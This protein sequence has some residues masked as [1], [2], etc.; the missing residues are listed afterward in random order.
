MDQEATAAS[1]ESDFHQAQLQAETNEGL[2]KEGLVAGLMLKL[3]EVSAEEIETRNAIEEKRLAVVADSAKARSRCR[4][5]TSS[6]SRPS[7][8]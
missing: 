8:P 1:V 5:R 7:P 2:Y 3:S 4:R 6:S